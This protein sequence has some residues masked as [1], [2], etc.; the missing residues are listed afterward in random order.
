[1]AIR[2]E[3]RVQ[4][5][6]TSPTEESDALLCSGSLRFVVGVAGSNRRGEIF[7]VLAPELPAFGTEWQ[8]MLGAAVGAVRSQ[9]RDH[10]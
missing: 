3:G 2:R 6:F 8:G 9:V 1:L 4:Q 7:K 5:F 10:R